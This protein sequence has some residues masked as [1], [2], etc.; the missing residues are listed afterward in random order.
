M[1]PVSLLLSQVMG[2]LDILCGSRRTQLKINDPDKIG[3]DPKK[4]VNQIASVVAH[5]WRM[6]NTAGQAGSSSDGFTAS[7]ANHPDFSREALRKAE[8]VLQRHLMFDAQVAVN[9]S[10]LLNKVSVAD[11]GGLCMLPCNTYNGRGGGVAHDK[12]METHV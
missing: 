10:A 2:F 11:R 4:L 1:L 5:A 6:E 3:F 8:A 7:L 9:F 12:T